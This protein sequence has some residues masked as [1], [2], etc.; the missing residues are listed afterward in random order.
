MYILSVL[1]SN[2]LYSFQ[3]HRR[4]LDSSSKNIRKSICHGIMTNIVLLPLLTQKSFISL[5]SNV[6]VITLCDSHN[7]YFF[8][9]L[10]LF[11]PLLNYKH[12]KC[13]LVLLQ[14]HYLAS[15]WKGRTD[16]NFSWVCPLPR[17]HAATHALFQNA[18]TLPNV[19]P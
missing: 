17:T 18:F 2:S 19:C 3:L 5:L 15:F 7:F 1:F 8:Q 11:V 10:Q 12:L 16:F 4:H 6:K 14:L 13:F 9:T